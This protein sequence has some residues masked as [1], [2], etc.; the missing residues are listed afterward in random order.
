MQYTNL[1]I[2]SLHLMLARKLHIKFLYFYLPKH[3]VLFLKDK[4]NLLVNSIQKAGTHML[5]NALARS[6]PLK[7]NER[8][9]YNHALV[10]HWTK[11]KADRNT[12][13][14]TVID[15]LDKQAWPGEIL[16][17]HIEYDE[18][19]ANFLSQQNTPHIFI[20]RKPIDVLLSLANW[21][22]RHNEIPVIPF[23]TYQEIESPQER[24][25]F[26][27]SGK[28]KEVQVWPDFVTRYQRFAGW[29][30]DSNCLTVRYE[31]L[32]AQPQQ[33]AVKIKSFVPL[34]FNEGRFLDELTNKNNR[35][36]TKKSEKV[37]TKLSPELYKVYT[38]LGGME[39]EKSFG[40]T[41]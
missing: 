10:Q 9:I 40:Y 38:E 23:I 3:H 28:R 27:L 11:D 1:L 14:Q 7:Y 24:L 37:F 17:G 36:F 16:R 4:P 15:F 41:L 18:E 25:A 31:D 8:G 30:N 12:T 26:L 21:W 20:I 13:P 6:L 19:L 33:V 2:E 35:T 29:I 39:L 34:K 22:E 5:T 32:V